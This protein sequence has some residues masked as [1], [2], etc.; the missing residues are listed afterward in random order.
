[1]L[2]QVP[3]EIRQGVHSVPTICGSVLKKIHTEKA[4]NH[5]FCTCIAKMAKLSQYCTP[6]EPIIHYP[7]N[8]NR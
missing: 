6:L 7:L 3:L 4:I 1:M 5:T 2:R 8:V